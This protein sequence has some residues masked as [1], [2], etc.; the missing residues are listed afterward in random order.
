MKSSKIF[1]LASLLLISTVALTGCRK[2]KE[3]IAKILV[4]DAANQ[5]VSGATVVLEADAT[6]GTPGQSVNTDYFPMT[7]TSNSAGE[8]VFNF[9]EIYQ[10]GQAGVVVLDIKVTA[11]A[12][13]GQG[14]IKVEEETTTEETVFI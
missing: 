3:T 1:F 10:L 6:Y 11:S 12:G 13:T 14:V 7:S 2:K 5:P 4:R 8:A 9:D